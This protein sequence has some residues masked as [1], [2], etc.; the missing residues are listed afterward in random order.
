MIQKKFLKS[1]PVCKATFT[2][3]KEMVDG[4][5]EV[6]LLGE[7]NGWN[8]K[9]AVKLKKQKNGNFKTTVELETGKEYEF[10]YLLDGE[11]WENDTEA[12][13]LVK[14]VFGTENFVVTTLN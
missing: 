13:K 14:G 5:K 10:R 9:E 2:L 11:K 3:N 6:L 7:I 8:V 12:D 1:K 4:A